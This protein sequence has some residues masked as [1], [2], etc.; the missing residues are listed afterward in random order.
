MFKKIIVPIIV[1]VIAIAVGIVLWQHGEKKEEGPKTTGLPM[2][3]TRYYWPGE[4][5]KEI[6][7]KKGWFKEAGLNIELIDTNPNYSQGLLDTVAGKIDT[8]D[9]T[10]VDVMKFNVQGTNLVLVV[11]SDNTYGAE[12]IV[13]KSEIENISD[14]KGKT[15]GVDKGN[16]LDYIL[17]VVLERNGLTDND[18]VKIN[19]SAENAA[20]EFIKGKVDAIITW[21]PDV[22]KAIIKGNGRKLFDTS[23]LSGISPNGYAFNRSF[24]EKRPGDVQAFVNVWHKTTQFLIKNPKEAFYI[25]ATIY[26][27]TP[28]EV[29]AF[30]RQIKIL[31]LRDNITAFSYGSGFESLHCVARKINNFMIQ[32]EMTNEQLD[33]TEFLDAQF[34]RALKQRG[35]R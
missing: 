3:I 28:D 23:E 21:E 32:K 5:W 15:V 30:Y 19:I 2:K 18:V 8:N 7:D 10:L 35:T 31:D 6:A 22:T 34:I 4:Y 26:D 12:A 24:I 25:I 27:K 33:S 29:Q 11:N 13:G 14:L 20:D 9:F 16:Y 17:Q 1:T